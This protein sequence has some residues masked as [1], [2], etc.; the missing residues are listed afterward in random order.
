M[1][2][3]LITSA[4]PYVNN[5]PHLGNIIGSVLSADVFARICRLSGFDT[6]YV[7]AT[8]EYGTATETKALEENTSPQQ[9]CDKYH[10]LHVQIYKDFAIDFDYFGRTSFPEQQEITQQVFLELSKNG[11]IQE[12]TSHQLYCPQDKMFLADR[13]VEGICPKCSYQ[14]ARGDQCDKCSALLQ[15]TDLISPKC[16]ICSTEPITKETCHLYIDLQK[17]TPQLSSFFEKASSKGKWPANALTLT[18]S[19]FK[20]GLLPRPISRDLSWGVP[21]PMAG[22]EKKVF[23]VW[24][25]AVLGYVSSTKRALGSAWTNWWNNPDEVLLYQFMA[26]DNIP[27]H[28]IMLPAMM[29]GSN[30]KW[31][32][33]HHI[34]SVEYLN[35]EGQKFSKSRN[36]GVFGDDIVK[37]GLPI[38]WWRFYLIAN[39]PET[40][41]TNFNWHKFKQ[42]VNANFIDNIGNLVNRTVVF[43]TK[44]FDGTISNLW[45][46][47]PLTLDFKKQVAL[48]VEDIT[49]KMQSA[50]LKNSLRTLLDLGRLTNK[51]FQ[52][53]APWQLIKQDANKANA[54]ISAILL[55]L[56]DIAILLQP[57]MPS[58][59]VKIFDQLNFKV[60]NFS[61]LLTWS[62]YNNHLIKKPTVLFT[63]LTD[64]QIESL[65]EKY[66]GDVNE[67]SQI[68]S[69]KQLK[70]VA[71]KIL[72]VSDHKGKE[73]L[74]VLK[75]DCSTGKSLFVVSALK[76]KITKDALLGKVALFVLN[77]SILEFDGVISEAMILTVEK[78]KVL[79]VLEVL[80][81]PGDRLTVGTND[82]N[83]EAN[84]GVDLALD[85]FK[86]AEIR[87]INGSL[88]LKDSRLVVNGQP[89]KTSLVLNGKVS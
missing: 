18:K 68:V 73:H 10:A 50:Q 37:I 77:L 87:V 21:I 16:K 46:K 4:L 69:F 1:K 72:S 38:D 5:V 62:N 24:F 28:T 19:W 36:I 14:N 44:Y 30:S 81:S 70:I 57:F 12:K 6:F 82:F 13:F 86:Q 89:V 22:Y 17:L 59:A 74:Y 47:E 2:K 76:G 51:L 85:V 75:V 67:S 29:L 32:T 34:S 41:D 58:M 65:Q 52:E 64:E 61:G 79:E 39:R 80:A 23:Y 88:M 63:K 84:E 3:I 60:T 11:F 40:A 15:P 9:I 54:I 53:T 33:L 25:D 55:T 83:N 45:Q 49:Q 78:K 66:S 43:C 56:R 31:T 8:D 7:C 42:E 27:F 35:Y 48:N 71:G 26:K 20:K